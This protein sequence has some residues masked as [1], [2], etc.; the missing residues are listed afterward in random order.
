MGKESFDGIPNGCNG[1][2]D[3]LSVV[4][5]NGVEKGIL[6]PSDFVRVTSAQTAK[7]F[8]MYPRKGVIMQGADA[9]IVVWDP[10]ATKII[11]SKTHHH[12][13][14]FNIFEGMKV[15]GLA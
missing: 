2:E 8:N 12:A 15:K 9:D 5:N 6:T 3:R 13:G 7:I 11:S 14:D 10:E 4:W 1:I